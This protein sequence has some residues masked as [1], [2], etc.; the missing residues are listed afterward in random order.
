MS[1]SELQF[2]HDLEIW[3]RND[4]VR[5]PGR[6]FREDLAKR[7]PPPTGPDGGFMEGGLVRPRTNFRIRDLRARCRG[8]N[9]PNHAASY[10]GAGLHGLSGLTNPLVPA[11]F[12]VKAG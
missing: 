5:S 7:S 1:N 6:S 3:F 12:E 9:A 11:T 4:A 8:L 2:V 10:L